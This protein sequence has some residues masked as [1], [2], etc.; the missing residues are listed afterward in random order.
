MEDS[1]LNFKLRGLTD[2]FSKSKLKGLVDFG[3]NHAPQYQ[4][5]HVAVCMQYTETRSRTCL[6][7]F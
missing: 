4:R 1:Q 6:Q 5:P 7:L 3:N 2:V